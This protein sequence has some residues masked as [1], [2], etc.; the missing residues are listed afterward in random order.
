MLCCMEQICV[1]T[2]ALI[3]GGI[4]IEMDVNGS[5]ISVLVGVFSML[6]VDCVLCRLTKSACRP[7]E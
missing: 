5:V 7:T 2:S 6:M 3:D 1:L 4:S